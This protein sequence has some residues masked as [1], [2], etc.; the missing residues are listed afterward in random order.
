MNDFI[1]MRQRILG[2]LEFSYDFVSHTQTSLVRNGLLPFLSFL[3]VEINLLK[4]FLVEHEVE[5]D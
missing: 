3:Y 2:L 4:L 1:W 5:G